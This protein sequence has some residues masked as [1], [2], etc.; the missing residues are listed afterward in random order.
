MNLNK[1]NT[2]LVFILFGFIGFTCVLIS[3]LLISAAVITRRSLIANSMLS[4]STITTPFSHQNNLSSQISQTQTPSRTIEP[5]LFSI[6]PTDGTKET[7][8]SISA[9]LTQT[10]IAPTII[11]INPT[12]P[13]STISPIIF[14]NWCVPW[15]TETKLGVVTR[16][17]DGVTIEVEIDDEIRTVRYL[18]LAL[19][20]DN[21]YPNSSQRA[22]NANVALVDGQKVLLVKD[23]AYKDSDGLLFRYVL[24]NG[25]FVNRD[26]VGN[27]FVLT[28][29]LPSEI[30]CSDTLIEAELAAINNQR[31]IF[32]PSPTPTRAIILNPTSTVSPT[33]EIVIT[34]IQPKGTGWQDPEEYIEGRYPGRSRR[35]FTYGQESG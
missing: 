5:P 35:F 28:Y 31:G 29:M 34:K 16:V 22:S 26:L 9:E 6:Q 33:G 2:F 11:Y 13:T 3:G 32:A 18:G 23:L 12:E 4:T 30:S 19:A 20:N 8:G 1:Q 24:S 27:G 21:D 25:V 7:S 15:H 10:S 17:I 14:D